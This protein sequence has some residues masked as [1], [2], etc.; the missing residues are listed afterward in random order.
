MPN[1]VLS[2]QYPREVLA[3]A[4]PVK[5]IKLKQYR[6]RNCSLTYSEKVFFY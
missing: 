5:K 1:L 6:I 3:L 2:E 4:A